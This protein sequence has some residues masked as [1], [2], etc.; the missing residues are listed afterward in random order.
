MTAL[1]RQHETVMALCDTRFH[2]QPHPIKSVWRV[3]RSLPGTRR[4]EGSDT[5]PSLVPPVGDSVLPSPPPAPSSVCWFGCGAA[6]RGTSFGAVER[7]PLRVGWHLLS[8]LEPVCL[9]PR[10]RGTQPALGLPQPCF[11]FCRRPRLPKG[12]GH[13]VRSSPHSLGGASRSIE[14]RGR[15]G[16]PPEEPGGWGWLWAVFLE[17]SGQQT[18]LFP[19]VLGLA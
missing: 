5:M 14:A 1:V 2:A 16:A 15:L 3:P 18:S 13:R 19:F 7:F 11:L 9:A 12:H 8:P 4:W 17:S 6:C 10:A